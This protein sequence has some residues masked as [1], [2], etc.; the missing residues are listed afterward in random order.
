MDRA[1][2]KSAAMK[3]LVALLNAFDEKDER[4]VSSFQQLLGQ[5]LAEAL[6][7]LSDR[8]VRPSTSW[9]LKHLILASPEHFPNPAWTPILLRAMLHETDAALFEEGCRALVQIGGTAETDA[10]RQ[11]AWQRQEPAL[12]ATVAR[13]LAWLEPRQP[14]D[15]HFRD[16]L[17]GG[18]NPHLSQQAA[19]H[20]AAMAPLDHLGELQTACDHPNTMASL[21]ALKVVAAIRRPEAGHFLLERFGEVCAALLLDNQFRGIQ[22]Q[23]RRAPAQ[24]V[25][26]VVLELLRACPGAEPHTGTLAE[27]D[28]TLDDPAADALTL[29]QHLRVSIQGLREI[30]LVDCLADLALGRSVRLANLMPEAPEELRHRTHRLQSHLDACAEGLARFARQGVLKKAE[31]LPLFLRAYQGGVGGDGFGQSFA[32][33]LDEGDRVQMELILQASNHHWREAGIKILGEREHPELLPFFLKAMADP[34]VDNAQLAIRYL[35]KLPGS[36]EIA[37]GLFRSGKA[38]QIERALDIFSLNAMTSAGPFLVEYLERAERE[39]LMISVIRCLGVLNY[40]PAREAFTG[41]LRFGQSPRLIRALAEGLVELKSIEAAR[42]LLQKATEL[43]NPE[44]QLLAVAGIAQVRP[45]FHH[46]LT[47]DEGALVEQL[48]EACFSEGMGFRIQAIEVSRNL[49]TLEAGL[50]ERW[51][52]RIS[53]LIAEQSKRF[54]WDR[55]Q[56]QMAAGVV[57]ELQRRRKELG[58]LVSRG[59]QIRELVLAYA[60]GDPIGARSLQMMVNALAQPG[61]FLGLEARVELEALIGSELIRPGIDEG[62]L[63]SLCRMA[64]Q[65]QGPDFM[66]PLVDLLQRCAPQSTLRRV[67]AEALQRLG[68]PEHRLSEPMPFQEI[69]VLDPSSFSRKRILGA[70]QG[71]R[72]REA[73]DRTEAEALM[74]AM[75]ADLLISEGSDSAGDLQVW[76]AD[77]WRARQFRQAV[78]STVFRSALSLPDKPWFAGALFKPYP[79]EELLA[80]IPE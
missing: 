74:R 62:S 30:R 7:E 18:Q 13:N 38:D 43:R 64:G 77:L 40:Q 34:I 33:I 63:E 3:E 76:F 1:D 49:W 45:D 25:K 71:R 11:I 23:I 10:L 14:F 51:E 5:I 78:L 35:G 59:A 55:D 24:S 44:I 19:L 39:D 26:T 4:D 53:G 41:L 36:Y 72:V 42:N 12:Q 22:E 15:Y 31:V 27:I 54:T 17:L 28:T 37:L 70:L 79:M 80:L 2:V 29:V 61:M 56:Q 47:A 46:V 20:L 9:G 68:Y 16:L 48:L 21:L 66:A 60:P 52:S 73:R 58:E 67:C 69:L 50:Y 6:P 65:V 32:M 57:R 75:P 8:L